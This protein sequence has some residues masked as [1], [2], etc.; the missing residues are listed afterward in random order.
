MNHFCRKNYQLCR[1]GGKRGCFE[2]ILCSQAESFFMLSFLCL[3][4]AFRDAAFFQ[5]HHFGIQYSHLGEKWLYW[6]L[7]NLYCFIKTHL[8][9]TGYSTVVHRGNGR[10]WSSEYHL[11]A[12]PGPRQRMFLHTLSSSFQAALW[13][14]LS[15][16]N[17]KEWVYF[18]SVW[19]ILFQWCS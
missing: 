14:C 3:G 18:Q 16:C 4:A 11:P 12:G 10:P 1:F 13:R 5:L 15:F 17:H 9:F 8:R 7:F 19:W 2:H 6:I